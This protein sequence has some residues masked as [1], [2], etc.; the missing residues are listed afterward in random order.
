MQSG[1]RA[2][3]LIDQDSSIRDAQEHRGYEEYGSDVQKDEN[4]AF[5]K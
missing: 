4:I 3:T 1:Q 5:Q 2:A